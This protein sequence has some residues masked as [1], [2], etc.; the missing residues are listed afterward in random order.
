MPSGQSAWT[1]NSATAIAMSSASV[2]AGLLMA[3]VPPDGVFDFVRAGCRFASVLSRGRA[4][5]AIPCRAGALFRDVLGEY[6]DDIALHGRRRIE[7]VGGDAL[8]GIS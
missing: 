2:L 5:G 7:H 3:I 6:S 8:D 4:R 1:F